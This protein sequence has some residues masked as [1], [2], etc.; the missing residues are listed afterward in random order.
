MNRRTNAFLLLFLLTITSSIGLTGPADQTSRNGDSGIVSESGVEYIHRTLEVDDKKYAWTIIIPPT[1]EKGAPGILFLNG[2]GAVGDDGKLHLTA[3]FVPAIEIAPEHWPFVV[4]APQKPDEGEWDFHEE[5]VLKMMDIAVEEGYVEKDKWA[6][7]GLSQGG[8]GTLFFASEHPDMFIAAAPVCGYAQI[9]F[10]KEG[11]DNPLPSFE[12]YLALVKDLA[13]KLKDIPVWIFHG[14]ADRTVPV[15]T[16]RM[17][18]KELQ[19][20]EA[21]VQ[22]TEFPGVNHDAWD[23]AYAMSELSDWFK[24]HLQD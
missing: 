22:Y 12:S 19:L 9:A 13:E 11:K 5:A 18:Y 6:L 4:I 24:Q 15:F 14:D 21:D 17:L 16:S 1:A 8:H 3:G 23:P 10:D 20:A 2:K 7:T